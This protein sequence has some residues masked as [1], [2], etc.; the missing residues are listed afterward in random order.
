MAE[1]IH[2]MKSSIMMIYDGLTDAQNVIDFV[3]N[4][5]ILNPEEWMS[6]VTA[7]MYLIITM[8]WSEDEEK[9]EKKKARKQK[10]RIGR[11]EEEI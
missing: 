3:E 4:S 9:Q 7:E 10:A 11:T 5:W 1:T 8:I 2:M 6:T